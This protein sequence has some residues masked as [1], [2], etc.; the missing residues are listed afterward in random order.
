MSTGFYEEVLPCGGKLKV[1]KESW[2]INYYFPGPDLRHN[3]L[4][5]VVPDKN[6]E[7]YIL[8][9]RQ[10]WEEFEELKSSIPT[11]GEFTKEGKMGM[12]IRIA[13]FSPGVCIKSYHMPINSLSHLELVLNGYNY[14]SKRAQAVQ[15]LL[16]SL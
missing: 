10:N 14:A 5:I 15:Q 16:A 12:M 9:F 11:G 7:N 8:A 1:K 3:G 2:E 4:F 13:K 6:I